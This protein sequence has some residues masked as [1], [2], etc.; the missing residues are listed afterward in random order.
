MTSTANKLDEGTNEL[1]WLG[2]SSSTIRT[3][4]AQI[5]VVHYTFHVHQLGHC[6]GSAVGLISAPAWIKDSPG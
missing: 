2:D 1:D 6:V 3:G 4:V 5:C